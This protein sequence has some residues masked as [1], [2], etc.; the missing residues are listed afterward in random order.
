MQM[1]L[2]LVI[3]FQ[4]SSFLLHLDD[5]SNARQPPDY[6]LF[7]TIAGCSNISH[8]LCLPFIK[9]S[10]NTRSYDR[11]NST[12]FRQLLTRN[13]ESIL[14]EYVCVCLMMS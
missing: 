5:A 1:A 6:F 8:L 10:K 2:C 14:E 4:W 3:S 12:R 9:L 7:H 13:S 11:N